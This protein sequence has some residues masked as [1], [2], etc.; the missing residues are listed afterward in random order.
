MGKNTLRY[1]LESPPTLGMHVDFN[2][3]GGSRGRYNAQGEREWRLLG[4]VS[5]GV[6][7]T[8]NQQLRR[9]RFALTFSPP[10]AARFVRT[11]MMYFYYYSL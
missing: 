3:R 5:V 8:R 1:T 11:A 2:R 9:S 6:E 10:A 7:R 4:E